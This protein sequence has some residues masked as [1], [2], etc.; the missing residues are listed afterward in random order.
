[1]AVGVPELTLITANLALAVVCPP[2]E[3]STVELLGYNSPDVWF[4]KASTPPVAH[5]PNVG[6]VP[7]SK[8]CE[9]VPAV[10]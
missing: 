6:V 2:T 3:K 4:Q 8:H 10:T 9:D 1:M 7:P 5:D